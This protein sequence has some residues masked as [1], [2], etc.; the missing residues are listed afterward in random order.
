MIAHSQTPPPLIILPSPSPATTTATAAAA[1]AAAANI[2]PGA[3]LAQGFA[4]LDQQEHEAALCCFDDAQ[5]GWAAHRG[6]WW[7]S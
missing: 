1:A 6:M 3:S 2:D 7:G 4:W 5:H